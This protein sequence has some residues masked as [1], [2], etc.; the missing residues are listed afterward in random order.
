M[1][2]AAAMG[3]V[4]FQKGLGGIHALS[5][6]V[7]AIYNTHHGLTNAMFTPY[8]LRANRSAVEQRIVRL[9][10]WLDIDDGFDGF[11]R[12]VV[13]TRRELAIPDTLAE[14]GVDNQ[15]FERLA[16][17]AVA[18]PSAAGNPLPLTVDACLELLNA[19][20]TGQR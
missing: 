16:L 18:D 7:G 5:H 9:A 19:A 10:A 8:V 3:A 2:S 14:L 13:D 12:F 20:W 1:L 6:P 15:Q 17:R 11:L 4:A